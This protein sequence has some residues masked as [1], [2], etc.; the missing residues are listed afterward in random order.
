MDSVGIRELKE[1]TSEILRRVR[2]EGA[3]IEVTYRGQAVAWL[4]PVESQVQDNEAD[5]I[6]ASLDELAARVGERW[7]GGSAAEAV[8]EIR[9]EL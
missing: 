6:L 1:R 7:P 8:E 5:M 9:R 3:I 2:E 4:V